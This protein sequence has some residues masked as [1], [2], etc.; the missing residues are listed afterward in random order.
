MTTLQ[1]R[2]LPIELLVVDV[3]GVLT[4]GGIVLGNAGEEL[5]AFHVRDGYGFRRWHLAG[6]QSAI[7]TGRESKLVQRRALEVGITHVTQS[8]RDKLP[9]LV[10]LL[11]RLNLAAGQVAYV[12]DD[13]PDVPCLQRV[14][15]A[16]AVAD[17][18]PETRAVAH[19]VTT[20]PGGAGAV[21]EGIERILRCQGAWA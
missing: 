11:A 18:C 9:A 6:K 13:L 17:A 20:A 4:A 7:I 16:V 21:R 14:G 10:N 19:Y 8:A 12:G 5:K 15:L 2:C 3:D 1:Q